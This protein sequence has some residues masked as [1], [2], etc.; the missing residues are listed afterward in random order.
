MSIK[1]VKGD[2]IKAFKAG[3]INIFAHGVN[4]QGVMGSGIAKQVRRELPEL[5]Q[6]YIDLVD[7]KDLGDISLHQYKNDQWAYNLYSQKFYGT[8][9]RHLNYG[10]L[11]KALLHMRW[12]ILNEGYYPL[13]Q[14]T[15]G[16]PKIGAGLGGGNWNVIEE[17]IESSLEDFKDVFVYE[18]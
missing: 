5:Y 2:V 12:Q 10:A 6:V 3:D 17:L 4:C 7:V 15:V 9:K 11:N 18:L 8:D 16:L 1:Y 14:L 13:S